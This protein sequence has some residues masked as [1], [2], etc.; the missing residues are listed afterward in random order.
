[1]TVTL[2]QYVNGRLFFSYEYHIINNTF[3]CLEILAGK[4]YPDN[5]FNYNLSQDNFTESFLLSD[6]LNEEILEGLR[7]A[8]LKEEHQKSNVKLTS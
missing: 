3:Y 4:S 1:M 8:G 2:L 6:V 7:K 5:K